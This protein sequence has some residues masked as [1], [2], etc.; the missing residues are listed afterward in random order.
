MTS[1]FQNNNINRNNNQINNNPYKKSKS[2]NINNSDFWQRVDKH[3]ERKMNN[4]SSSRQN[5]N[6]GK[7]L[8]VT[9]NVKLINNLLQIK[10][11]I[12]VYK[13]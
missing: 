6:I 7:E 12:F 5:E 4:Q 8:I 1:P 2:S 10:T 11:K 3:K 9:K 13:H